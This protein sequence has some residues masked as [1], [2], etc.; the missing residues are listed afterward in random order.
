MEEHE[1]ILRLAE[2]LADQLRS[3][4]PLSVDLWD[5]A[6][7]AAYVKRDPQVVRERLACVPSFP[8]AIRLPT[9]TG[10]TQPLYIAAEVIKWAI[11][12]QEKR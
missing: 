11:S 5:I 9:K 2:A 12:H 8:R 1:L 10:R 4:I 3:E 7:I 6:T